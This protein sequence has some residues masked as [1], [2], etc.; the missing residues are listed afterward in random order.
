MRVIVTKNSNPYVETKE[1]ILEQI[2]DE[3]LI[4][5]GYFVQHN[6]KYRQRKDHPKFILQQ[7]SIYTDIDVVE[8]HPLL[9]CEPCT[10]IGEGA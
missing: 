1:D 3:Y 2:V 10:G 4:Q 9:R 6:V 5:K 8:I 7:D